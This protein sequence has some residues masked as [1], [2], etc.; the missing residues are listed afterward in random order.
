MERVRIYCENL[1]CDGFVCDMK[2]SQYVLQSTLNSRTYHSLWKSFGTETIHNVIRCTLHNC[3]KQKIPK[4]MR[5]RSWRF[6]VFTQKYS[7]TILNITAKAN[8]FLILP[9][10]VIIF[11]TY[12]I[13]CNPQQGWFKGKKPV[14]SSRYCKY[15]WLQV[16][17]WHVASYFKLR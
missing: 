8:K 5:K 10:Q 16:H 9:L 7:K 14:S 17:K 11:S 1:H 4:H 13:D 15:H 2:C 12:I 6:Q 3:W